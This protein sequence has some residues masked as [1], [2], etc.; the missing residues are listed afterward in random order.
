[1][2]SAQHECN[3]GSLHLLTESF[4]ELKFGLSTE[5]S[6]KVKWFRWAKTLL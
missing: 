3:N 2:E 4:A 6:L 1:V 5:F